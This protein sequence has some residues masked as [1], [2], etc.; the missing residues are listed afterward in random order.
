M[1][2][3][4]SPYVLKGTNGDINKRFKSVNEMVDAFNKTF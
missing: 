4:D 2:N 1:K 3:L